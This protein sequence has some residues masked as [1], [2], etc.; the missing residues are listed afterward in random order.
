MSTHLKA[1]VF[2]SDFKSGRRSRSKAVGSRFMDPRL[3]V[4]TTWRGFKEDRGAC[5]LDPGSVVPEMAGGP[6][7]LKKKK[8]L[9]A[10]DFNV[11]FIFGSSH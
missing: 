2:S 3:H 9:S 8:K 10:G 5:A 7:S 4:R 6:E 1:L 11:R